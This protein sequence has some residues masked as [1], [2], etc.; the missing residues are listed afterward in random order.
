M[1]ETVEIANP[2]NT[3]QHT[4]TVPGTYRYFCQPHESNGMVGEV[5]V[6]AGVG[7]Q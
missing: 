4:F 5:V 1:R 3:Y 7:G 2:G 6:K